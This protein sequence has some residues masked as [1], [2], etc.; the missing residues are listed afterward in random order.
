MT[1][2]NTFALC[3]LWKISNNYLR[4]K[5]LIY[6]FIPLKQNLK[7]PRIINFLLIL[8]KLNINQIRNYCNIKSSMEKKIK[9][10]SSHTILKFSN[11]WNILPFYGTLPKWMWLLCSLNSTSSKIWNDYSEMFFKWG[12]NYKSVKWY[13]SAKSNI[14]DII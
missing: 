10:N 4:L 6:W 3:K 1:I 14:F 13:D 8:S 9:K 5:L 7:I 11:L 12:K 2:S